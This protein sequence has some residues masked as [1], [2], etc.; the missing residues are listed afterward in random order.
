M[1]REREHAG[2]KTLLYA[3]YLDTTPQF[4]FHFEHT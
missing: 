2:F 3:T 4:Y 1:W